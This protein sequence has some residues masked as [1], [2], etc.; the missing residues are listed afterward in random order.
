ML[1]K[2]R[3]CKNY[4]RALNCIRVIYGPNKCQLLWEAGVGNRVTREKK[5]EELE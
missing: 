2:C 5:G 3:V 1:C 4:E